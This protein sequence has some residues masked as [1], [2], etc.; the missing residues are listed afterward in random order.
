MAL[1][2]NKNYSQGSPLMRIKDYFKDKKILSWAFYDWANSAF[3]TSIMAA[4]FPTFFRDFWSHGVD[5]RIT[6]SRLGFSIGIASFIIA[7]LA[8]FLGAIADQVNAKKKFFLFFLTIG[9]TTTGALTF[10]AM[11]QWQIAVLLYAFGT[12]GF[13]GS[14]IFYDAF[15]VFISDEKSVDGVSAFGFSMGYLGGGLLFVLNVLT[16]KYPT[17]FGLASA[18]QAV[19]IS[20]LVVAIWW[21]FSQSPFSS[22]YQKRKS[23]VTTQ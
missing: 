1:G 21:A 17:L 14:N 2:L 22:S 13:S 23:K 19:Q 16:V 15:L 3:A 9:V 5:G 18:S 20:F 10:T 7:V 12:I 8:P 6:S 4:F 11:G